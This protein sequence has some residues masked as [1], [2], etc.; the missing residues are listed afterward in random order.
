[1]FSPAS[2]GKRRMISVAEA[3]TRLNE[4]HSA[5][6]KNSFRKLR[7]YK[8]GRST[9]IDETSVDE[10]IEQ[11]LAANPQNPQKPRRGRP[12]KHPLPTAAVAEQVEAST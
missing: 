8:V 1:M 5:F 2:D 9:K 6:Y 11:R 4:S 7:Y 3:E 10:L 12:R